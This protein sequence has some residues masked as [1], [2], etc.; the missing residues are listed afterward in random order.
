MGDLYLDGKD[1]PGQAF[2]QVGMD[3]PVLDMGSF[4][5]NQKDA[6]E[7]ARQAPEILI[8]EPAS[9]RKAE[10]PD[11]ETI[12]PLV[13]ERCQGELFRCEAVGP[14][15]DECPVA[16][17][18]KGAVGSLE[19]DDQLLSA[20]LPFDIPGVDPDRIVFGRNLGRMEVF[21][22]IPGVLGI[23][24]VWLPVALQGVGEG[25]LDGIPGCEILRRVVNG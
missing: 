25:D 12:A 2:V 24:V 10:Y 21:L 22:S 11:S 16:E 9:Q 7:Q 20:L 14:V 15:A 17:E 5:R 19:A 18:R 4:Q 23:D 8:L 3:E 6:A 1:S 13:D